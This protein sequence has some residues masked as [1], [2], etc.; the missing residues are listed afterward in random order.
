[1]S[2]RA[3]YFGEAPV[4]PPRQTATLI[5]RL[6]PVLDRPLLIGAMTVLAS[7]LFCGAIAETR[8]FSEVTAHHA[9]PVCTIGTAA[10]RCSR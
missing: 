9:I 3:A 2:S 7:L 10:P 5:S 4:L 6:G 1:M 8:P